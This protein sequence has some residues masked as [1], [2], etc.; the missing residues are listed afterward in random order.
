[1]SA[2]VVVELVVGFFYSTYCSYPASRRSAYK[3]SRKGN[4]TVIYTTMNPGTRLT[5]PVVAEVQ[6]SVPDTSLDLYPSLNPQGVDP[7]PPY[8]TGAT[9]TAPTHAGRGSSFLQEATAPPAPNDLLERPSLGSEKL[10]NVVVP[11]SPQSPSDLRRKKI[12]SRTTANS[13]GSPKKVFVDLEM[14]T[15]QDTNITKN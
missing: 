14:N 12:N 6:I 10:S 5:T 4:R 11:I 3:R 8:I 9:P 2:F 13:A 1:M 15:I 7:F